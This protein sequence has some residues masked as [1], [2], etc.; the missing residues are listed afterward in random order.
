MKRKT[1]FDTVG[2]FQ[3]TKFARGPLRLVLMR[4]FW[5]EGDPYE[6][7][8]SPQVDPTPYYRSG[9]VGYSMTVFVGQKLRA[10]IEVGH[11]P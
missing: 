1:T 9:R 2:I 10:Q 5:P 6:V 7:G 8:Y 4:V 3:V 11:R